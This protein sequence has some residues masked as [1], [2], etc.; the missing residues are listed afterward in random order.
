MKT[1]SQDLQL[2]AKLSV[3]E[4]E[5]TAAGQHDAA[6]AIRAAIVL[7]R[8]GGASALLRVGA[9][10]AASATGAIP[11]V[12]VLAKAARTILSD[13][14]LVARHMPEIPL[15]ELRATLAEQAVHIRRLQRELDAQVLARGVEQR[16]IARLEEE[17]KNLRRQLRWQDRE[18]NRESGEVPWSEERHTPDQRL[19]GEGAS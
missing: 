10:F 1:M 17:N 18:A 19:T 8:F 2:L 15:E 14:S 9:Q 3:L 7:A 13:L 5:A 12:T 16:E 4:A 6:D 11:R